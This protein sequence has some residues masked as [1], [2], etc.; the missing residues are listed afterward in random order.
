MG[1]GGAGVGGG[2]DRG[3]GGWRYANMWKNPVPAEERG[4]PGAS[5]QWATWNVSKKWINVVLDELKQPKPKLI[6]HAHHNMPGLADPYMRD[7]VLRPMGLDVGVSSSAT[8]AN[9]T[10]PEAKELQ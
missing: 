5:H 2:F 6:V 4:A 1:E 3:L 10:R 8:A 7:V 9:E